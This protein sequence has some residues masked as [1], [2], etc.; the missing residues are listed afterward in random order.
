MKIYAIDTSNDYADKNNAK[1]TQMNPKFKGY[2]NGKFYSDEIILQAKK[3]L[4]NPEILKNFRQ[5]SFIDTYKTWHEGNMADSLGERVALAIFT[6]GISEIS[7]TFFGR[8]LDI[9]E[10]TE[11]EKDLN[12]I[13]NCMQDLVNEK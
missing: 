5:K 9:S 7:W 12:E 4:K 1:M 6:L 11:K 10:N 13:L 2:V 3:A 8:L